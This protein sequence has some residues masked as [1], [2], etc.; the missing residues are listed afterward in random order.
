VSEQ[1]KK[2]AEHTQSSTT[3]AH[4]PVNLVKGRRGSIREREGEEGREKRGME[5][6]SGGTQKERREKSR[7]GSLSQER[8]IRRPTVKKVQPREWGCLIPFS[9]FGQKPM[10]PSPNFSLGLSSQILPIVDL[11]LK[12]N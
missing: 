7:G 4:T 11:G 10:V 12:K 5:G 2:T 8:E 3:T 1:P 6:G 9:P